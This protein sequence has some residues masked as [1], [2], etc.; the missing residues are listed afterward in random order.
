MRAILQ[1]AK[2]ICRGRTSQTISPCPSHK[3]VQ[4]AAEN[5]SHRHS[6]LF[7]YLIDPLSPAIVST[8][9]IDHSLG[10][11]STFIGPKNL[12]GIRGF[13]GLRISA[14]GREFQTRG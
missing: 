4:N 11:S 10:C 7:T 13:I 6:L 9:L 8:D 5:T 1:K 14:A 12:F 3:E 2:I